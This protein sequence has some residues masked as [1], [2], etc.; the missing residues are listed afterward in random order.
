VTAAISPLCAGGTT[1]IDVANSQNGVSYQL[2]IGTTAVGPAVV[3]NGS[4][5][6][7]STG[8][9]NATTTFNVLA[10]NGACTPV[11]Y[12]SHRHCHGFRFLNSTLT[13]TPLAATV[14][15]G[16]ATS[17]QVFASENL[18]NYQLRN[19]TTNAIIGAPIA[20]NGGTITLPTGNFKCQH[21]L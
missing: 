6:S 9:L 8:V 20:G 17:I 11:Q 12:D 1:T 10:T 16:S 13:V 14:C 19:N 2:R 18:V 5:I 7:L 15:A 4:T 3:G 21:Y